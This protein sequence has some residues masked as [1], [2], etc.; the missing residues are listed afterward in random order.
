MLGNSVA[1][2]IHGTTP[3]GVFVE[4][5]TPEGVSDLSGN[6]L[7]WTGSLYGA[8]MDIDKAPFA[9]PYVRDDGREDPEAGTEVRRVLRGGAWGLGRDETR[10]AYRDEYCPVDRNI[11]IGFRVAADSSPI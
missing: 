9:N 6:P 1:T 10:A 7:E 4:G 2:K 11:A 8:G 5:Q 3:V